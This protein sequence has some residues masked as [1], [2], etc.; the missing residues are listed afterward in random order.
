MD[1]LQMCSTLL[2]L[3]SQYESVSHS[4]SKRPAETARKASRPPCCH[5]NACYTYCLVKQG[6]GCTGVVENGQFANVQYIVV[7]VE[8]I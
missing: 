2:S 7:L 3:W 1:N 8:P 6:Q 5:Q 4:A